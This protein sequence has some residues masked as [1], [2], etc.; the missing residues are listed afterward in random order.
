MNLLNETIDAINESGH[1]VEQ[2]IFIGSEKTGHQCTWDE[3]QTLANREYDNGYG[4][5]VVATDLIIV[6]G[7]GTKLWRGEYD[8]SEWWEFSRPFVKPETCNPIRDLFVTRCG[9]QDLEDINRS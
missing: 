9:W 6:F 2:I 1:S 8:G 4:A 5:Q 3:F 7:D